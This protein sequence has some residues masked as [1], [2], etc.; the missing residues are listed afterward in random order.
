MNLLITGGAGFIGSNF[1]DYILKHHP[2]H[3]VLVLDKLTYAGGM[4]NLTEAE[5]NPRFRFI[6]GDIC[7]RG[8]DD[9]LVADSD[10]VINF[11]AETHVDRSIQAPDV[12]LRTNILGAQ[13]LLE[14][15]KKHKKRF[16]QISTDEVYGSREEGGFT[17]SDP[18]NPSSPYAASKAAGDLLTLSY[19][20]T[21]GLPVMIIRCSNNYG[22]RQ[23]PEKLLPL[24]IVKALSGERLPLY[25]DGLNR[26]EWTYV[27]DN[28]R[29]IE[30][31]LQ[32]GEDGQIYNISSGIELTN[33]QIIQ[34]ILKLLGKSEDLIEFVSDRPGHDRRYSLSIEKMAGLGWKPLYNLQ[35]GLKMTVSWYLE[36]RE[37]WEKRL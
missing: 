10:L 27:E 35:R 13:S 19:H 26:R 24:F 1:V 25:G 30:L 32:K 14:A 21:Y 4:D 18:L 22:P 28:C 20:K 12:F 2:D 6:Q 36:N 7:D 15:T 16:I 5:G 34:E 23:Y 11:A 31:I 33:I 17:E 37:W 8:I 3:R 9:E 29:A